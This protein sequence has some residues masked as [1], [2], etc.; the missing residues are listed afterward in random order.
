MSHSSWTPTFWRCQQVLYSFTFCVC[1]IVCSW[2]HLSCSFSFHISYKL[3]V[4]GSSKF[5][6]DIS[7]KNTH[8]RCFHAWKT[9]YHECHSFFFFFSFCHSFLSKFDIG[10]NG[11]TD[12][13]NEISLLQSHLTDFS[14]KICRVILWPIKTLFHYIFSFK[15][16]IINWWSLNLSFHLHWLIFTLLWK[17]LNNYFSLCGYDTNLIAS[18]VFNLGKGVLISILEFFFQIILLF[19]IKK[20]H[21]IQSLKYMKRCIFWRIESRLE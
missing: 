10:Y 19:Y 4:K 5:W 14:K 12:G 15:G 21:R 1:R 18:C 3:K 9:Q 6:L 20:T 17:A 8:G 16:F 2:S 7:G 11:M 13:D